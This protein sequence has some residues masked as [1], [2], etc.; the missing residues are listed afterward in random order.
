MIMF[1]L[2]KLPPFEDYY[3]YPSMAIYISFGVVIVILDELNALKSC[4]M[5]IMCAIVIDKICLIQWPPSPPAPT[6]H[7]AIDPTIDSFITMLLVFNKTK[8]K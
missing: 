3:Y 6:L 5:N 2:F 8:K 7:I 1:P 4:T